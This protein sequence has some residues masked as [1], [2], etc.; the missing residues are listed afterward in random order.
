[1]WFSMSAGAV[2]IERRLEFHKNYVFIFALS[3]S[4]IMDRKSDHMLFSRA[5][6]LAV[7]QLEGLEV[8]LL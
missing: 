1:M 5:W 7:L 8:G 6:L 3:R 2:G 4:S